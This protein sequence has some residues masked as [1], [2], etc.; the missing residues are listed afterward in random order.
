[1]ITAN[2]MVRVTRK[3][4]NVTHLALIVGMPSVCGRV[5]FGKPGN[6]ADRLCKTCARIARVSDS[7]GEWTD[8][9]RK[10]IAIR[11]TQGQWQMMA[12]VVEDYEKGMDN[13]PSLIALYR[14]ALAQKNY[15]T[16]VVT[17]ALEKSGT[18]GNS[19]GNGS[20][21]TKATGATPN[22]RAALLRMAAFADSLRAQLAEALGKNA[23]EHTLSETYTDDYFNSLDRKMIDTN[24]SMVSAAIENLKKELGDA[25]RNAVKANPAMEELKEG[26]YGNGEKIWKV[27]ISQSSGKPYAM[28]LTELS[29]PVVMKT[30]TKTHEFVYAP[31]EIRNITPDMLLSLDEAKSFGRRTGTCCCCGRTLTK[32]ISIENGIGPICAEGF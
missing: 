29:E 19:N 20:G 8:A 28:L 15:A 25:K 6:P 2:E 23:P 27:K 4:G 14:A 26:M 7:E 24:F 30:T 13:D 32:K 17:G 3:G 18:A 11:R 1:M 31:G 10:F 12:D 5:A 16:T 9:Q 22:Q 21:K